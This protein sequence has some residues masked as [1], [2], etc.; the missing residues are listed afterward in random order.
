MSRESVNRLAQPKRHFSSDRNL[1]RKSYLP[2]AEALK[3]FHNSTPERFRTKPKTESFVNGN[4]PRKLTATIPQSPNLKTTRRARPVEVISREDQEKLEFDE[5]Q[6][7]KIKANPVNKKILQG[8]MKTT[9]QVQKKPSTVQEPF[10]L[11]APVKKVPTSPKRNLPEFHARP[12][13]KAV[14]EQPKLKA[15]LKAALTQPQAPSFM[16]RHY[17]SNE[18]ISKPEQSQPESNQAVRPRNT[19]PLPFSFELRDLHIKN[20]RQEL[21]QKVI[22]EEKKAREFHA[23]PLPKSI[24]QPLKNRSLPRAGSLK[25]LY[26]NSV[27][28]SNENLPIQFKARPASVLNKKPFEPKKTEKP[29]IEISE[30]TLNTDIRSKEREAFE[31]QKKEKDERLEQYKQMEEVLRL[32]QEAEEVA[33]SRKMAEV[34]AQPVKKYKSVT[35][36]PSGKVT[37][38]ISPKFQTDIIRKNRSH[39]KENTQ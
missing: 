29:L 22:E 18:T 10:K 25:N 17:K 20:K 2:M 9:T 8:P 28:K 36:Q 31:K 4:V 5:A 27:D 33:R 39:D 16:K 13:P 38:P 24:S 35:I 23:Q 7:F 32:Q 11:T 1:N 21:V 30:F 26:S 15:P 19:K 3:K 37:N 34:R 14:H 12:V 6:K